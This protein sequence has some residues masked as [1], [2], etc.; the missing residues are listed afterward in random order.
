MIQNH[1]VQIESLPGLRGEPVRVESRPLLVDSE[2]GVLPRNQ[3]RYHAFLFLKHRPHGL[4]LL[5]VVAENLCDVLV[6]Q[7]ILAFQLCD[8][9]QA[10]KV[11]CRRMQQVAIQQAVVIETGRTEGIA[12]KEVPLPVVPGDV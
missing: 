3:F 1:P 12:D 11:P 8:L 2:V 10:T 6:H 4:E 5:I 9:V 7:P